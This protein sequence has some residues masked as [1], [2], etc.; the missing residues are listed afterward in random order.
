ASVVSEKFWTLGDRS[1]RTYSGILENHMADR[2]ECS[3]FGLI[4][5]GNEILDARRQDAH[6]EAA[7][8]ILKARSIAMAYSMILPDV[9]EIIDAQLAWAMARPEP[10]FCC[11]GIGATPDDYTRQCVA[12]VAGVPIERHPEGEAILRERLGDRS[13]EQRLR[14][15]DFPKGAVLIPNP[16]N[17]IPGF[18]VKNGHF[19][20]GFPEMAHPMMEWVLEAWFEEGQAQT[21]AKLL[22]P[23]AR[24]ADL[25]HTMEV[26]IATN[27]ELTFSS[28][29]MYLEDRGPVVEL[30]IKGPPAAVEDGLG[31]L[32]ML[33]DT[34]DVEWE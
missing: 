13:T 12:R 3:A 10:F 14:M 29:P 2:E 28:L 26:F 6:F 8:R 16:V 21:S 18:R 25:V 17:R 27:P 5:I 30:G 34:E 4:I 7:I 32:K 9:P 20:P 22:L 11:G 31:Y 19:L 15:I 24:E 1:Y 33:L 23:D